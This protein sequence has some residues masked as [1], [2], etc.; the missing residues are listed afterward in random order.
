MEKN[1]QVRSLAYL[2]DSLEMVY[3]TAVKLYTSGHLNRSKLYKP[4]EKIKQ[5]WYSARKQTSF[6]TERN[7][8]PAENERAR[9]MKRSSE[10]RGGDRLHMHLKRVELGV[11]EIMVLKN[12]PV[13]NSHCVMELAK[14]V[15]QFIPSYAAGVTKT[16]QFNEFL[17]FQK[18]FI[19]KH[20]LLQNDFTGS[21]V[22]EEHERKL[23]K[24]LQKICDCDLVHFK[25][26]V[27]EE[28]FEDI[29][30]SV[31]T[32][33]DILKEIQAVK[34]QVKGMETKPSKAPEIQTFGP[35]ILS[36]EEDY[37]NRDD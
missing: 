14:D 29:C 26:Q 15:Y 1:H 25:L 36:S 3:R 2:F 7:Q 11:S 30:N 16:E 24:E 5:R 6:M 37:K 34:A 28:V 8:F 23:P 17:H 19:A 18:Q 20:E 10:S 32:F 9:K 35:F 22:S 13:K 21:K 31:L 12:K 4:S 33:C 27:A